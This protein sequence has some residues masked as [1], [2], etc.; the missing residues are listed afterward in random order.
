[1]DPFIGTTTSN[2]DTRFYDMTDNP[3]LWTSRKKNA[4]LILLCLA[5]FSVTLASTSICSLLPKLA[6]SFAVVPLWRSSLA[7]SAY[8]LGFLGGPIIFQPFSDRTGRRPVLLVAV[9]AYT[10]FTIGCEYADQWWPFL[11]CRAAAGFTGSAVLFVSPRCVADYWEPGSK[12]REHGILTLLAVNVLGTLLG[13]LY[14]GVV[15]ESQGWQYVFWPLS[16]LVSPDSRYWEP[17]WRAKLIMVN[18]N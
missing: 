17:Q 8:I 13:P 12:E 1:M 15:A 6:E 9:L 18:S 3:L 11:W 2:L 4:S 7:L 5:T 16:V 14:G 10:S